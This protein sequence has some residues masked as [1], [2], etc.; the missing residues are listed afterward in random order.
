[1]ND[2]KYKVTYLD[3]FWINEARKREEQVF[4]LSVYANSEEQAR[5]VANELI[6]P[7]EILS[8]EEQC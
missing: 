6:C 3:K 7:S 8:I 2:K 4:T 5:A 1:M